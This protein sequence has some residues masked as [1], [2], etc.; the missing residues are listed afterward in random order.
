MYMYNMKAID[1]IFLSAF[2]E[3]IFLFKCQKTNKKHE[4]NKRVIGCWDII[5]F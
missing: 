3:Y 2:L 4:K 1:I 5:I